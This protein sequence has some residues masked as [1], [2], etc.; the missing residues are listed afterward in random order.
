M[1]MQELGLFAYK[2]VKGKTHM[3]QACRFEVSI[4]VVSLEMECA[5]PPTPGNEPFPTASNADTML[6]PT[7]AAVF[8]LL[9]TA[10]L[11]AVLLW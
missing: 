9:S 1:D 7:A 11:F 10:L 5:A 6:P 2:R 3:W 4:P 8:T